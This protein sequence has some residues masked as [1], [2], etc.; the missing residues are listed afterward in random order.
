MTFVELEGGPFDGCPGPLV[1]WHRSRVLLVGQVLG[2]DDRGRGQHRASNRSGRPSA[3]G[4]EEGVTAS[5]PENVGARE[6][7]AAAGQS[8]DPRTD[9][10]VVRTELALDRTQLAW[11]RTTFA[12]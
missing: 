9:L 10:A 12:L 11:I 1:Y 3:S 2:L 6:R 5:E 4:K 7:P 8:A